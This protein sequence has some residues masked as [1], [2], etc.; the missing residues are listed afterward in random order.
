MPSGNAFAPV[1][2]QWQPLAALLANDGSGA[3]AA[4]TRLS[5]QRTPLRDL[6]DALHCLCLL[7]GH[8]PGPIDAARDRAVAPL[9]HEWLAEAAQGFAKERD[10]LTRLVSAVGPMPSTVN[11]TVTETVIATQRHAIE[12]LACSDRWGCALGASV[13]LVLD[14]H[15]VRGLLDRVGE[16]LGLTPPPVALPTP[17]ASRDVF[18]ASASASNQARAFHFGAQQLLAQQ[19]GL[20]NLIDARSEAR[21][22]A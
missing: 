19:R 15:D 18:L 10:W 21:A 16:R 11:Q 4:L 7:H 13:A 3:S 1:A 5:G 2:D 6:A 9:A 22:A 20:W 14:W 17:A 8:F 12:M